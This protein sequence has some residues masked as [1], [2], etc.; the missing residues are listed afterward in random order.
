M[1]NFSYS[2]IQRFPKTSNIRHM[3]VF[4]RTIYVQLPDNKVIVKPNFAK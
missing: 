1:P 4:E 3:A 2:T